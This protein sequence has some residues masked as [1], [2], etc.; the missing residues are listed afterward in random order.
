MWLPN[1][2]N[3]LRNWTACKRPHL[4]WQRMPAS[5]DQSPVGELVRHARRGAADDG[6]IERFLIAWP[7]APAAWREVDHWPESSAK[8]AA[9]EAFDRL[10]NLTPEVLQAERDTDPHGEARGLPFL[11]FDGGAR[12]AFSEWRGDFERM[13]RT[14]DAEGLE[15]AL[16]KF[17]HHVPALA[18]AVHTIDHGAGPVAL[19]ATLQALRLA[20]YFESHARRLHASG[21]RQQVRAARGILDKAR[22]G[23]LPDPFTARDVYRPQWAGLSEH[24][25]VAD[26]LDMLAGCG[27]LTEAT[28]DTSGRPTTVYSLAEGARNG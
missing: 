8:R 16:S 14:T 24:A 9:W 17:R 15:G 4:V 1:W 11:R 20:E 6:M 2:S 21:R 25:T 13:L 23:A 10:D 12:E 19:Q 28:I 7:D 18:L 3:C 27:W 26:A 22:S 5:R